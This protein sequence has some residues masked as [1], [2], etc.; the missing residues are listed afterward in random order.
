M[1]AAS[2]SA[3]SAAFSQNVALFVKN[4]V[5]RKMMRIEGGKECENDIMQNHFSSVTI[6]TLFLHTWFRE[7]CFTH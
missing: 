2:Q 6:L 5:K 3:E 7:S 1:L 4:Y